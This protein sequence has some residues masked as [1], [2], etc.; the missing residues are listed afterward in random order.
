MQE[1]I[2]EKQLTITAK[3]IADSISEAEIRIIT[4]QLRYPHYIHPQLL[5]HRVFSRNSSSSR[6]I[7]VKKLIQDVIDDPVYP[8]HWGKNQQGMQAREECNEMVN[9]WLYDDPAGT[10]IHKMMTREQAWDDEREHAIK[11]AQAYD[12]AGYHKQIVNRLLEPFSHINVIVTATEWE[13]FFKLRRHE[14]A[15]PE[16][17][18]LGDAVYKAIEESK[19]KLVQQDEWHL[20]Y[21]TDEDLDFVFTKS[22]QFHSRNHL[23]ISLSAARCA[24]VSYLT[25]ENKKPTIEQDLNLYKRLID[26]RPPHMSPVEHQA[27]PD[28]RE[29]L[30]KNKWVDGDLH[31]NYR[32]WIQFR[33]MLEGIN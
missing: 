6:A 26:A 5:T 10:A 31:G 32:G 3:I 9:C 29:D 17:Q 12:A 1:Q 30:R 16:I 24:R 22:E 11:K 20:P 8:L 27:T 2:G 23:L 28:V 19:P 4:V 13:N 7:P 14:D 15:Q 25:H 33:K 18:A 21:L